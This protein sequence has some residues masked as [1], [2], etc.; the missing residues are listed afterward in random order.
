MH[1][2]LDAHYLFQGVLSR[3][4]TGSPMQI[5][6]P[7]LLAP[8]INM[9]AHGE[10]V[11]A[12]VHQS[13][14][15]GIKAMNSIVILNVECIDSLLS[16]IQVLQLRD[17]CSRFVSLRI[18]KR[19]WFRHEDHGG[20]ADARLQDLAAALET[21]TKCIK[22]I[23]VRAVSNVTARG[24]VVRLLSVIGR[25]RTLKSLRWHAGGLAVGHCGV[26]YLSRVLQQTR[27]LRVLEC[28]RVRFSGT[29]EDINEFAEAISNSIHLESVELR[30]CKIDDNHV[31]TVLAK[32]SQLPKLESLQLSFGADLLHR[33]KTKSNLTVIDMSSTGGD[34]LIASSTALQTCKS[35]R[36]LTVGT[37]LQE[38]E[39]TVLGQ[40]VQTLPNLYWLDINVGTFNDD[41]HLVTL[42]N[43]LR[44]NSKM[45]T[46]S[47]SF[48]R[49]SGQDTSLSNATQHSFVSLLETSNFTLTSLSFGML[50]ID[51]VLDQKINLFLK[52]NRVGRK[53][54]LRVANAT[55][56]TWIEALES[57]TRDVSCLFY[58]VSSNPMLCS[59]DEVACLRKRS[60]D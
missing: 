7:L 33:F 36:V 21:T 40:L 13:T 54:L 53:K 41:A 55:K 43:A 19:S 57:C 49:I 35:C 16:A 60:Q 50:S 15:S 4:S 8:S 26:K 31:E 1:C 12:A 46:L 10:M 5:V 34:G 30:E 42:I 20:F 59:S 27:S 17:E 18:L 11:A 52:L 28:S 22:S 23:S 29:K 9:T 39:C 14:L 24:S 47:F 48:I 58:I 45:E 51:P 3:E 56:Q 6:P 25:V 2:S 38:T 37:S 32:V 44:E